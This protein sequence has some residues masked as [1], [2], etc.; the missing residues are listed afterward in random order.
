MLRPRQSNWLVLVLVGLLILFA[1]AIVLALTLEVLLLF[2]DVQLSD[3]S[4]LEFVELYLLDL[5][6][7]VIFGFVVYRLTVYL[8]RTEVADRLDALEALEAAESDDETEDR[9]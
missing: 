9:D 1:P 7:L 4:A 3:I 8:A 5:F 6:L 2:G